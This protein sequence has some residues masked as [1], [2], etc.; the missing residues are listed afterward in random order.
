MPDF[1]VRW[2][3]KWFV[4]NLS[5]ANLKKLLLV[6][7]PLLRTLIIKSEGKVDDK[8]LPALDYLEGWCNK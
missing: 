2:F 6:I 3:G 7:I 1:M 5:I 8:L 4:A